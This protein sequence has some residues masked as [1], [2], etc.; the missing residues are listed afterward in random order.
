MNKDNLTD[1]AMKGFWKGDFQ[2]KSL[3]GNEAFKDLWG[4]W[5]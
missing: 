2:K 4:R 5:L 3:I 1:K